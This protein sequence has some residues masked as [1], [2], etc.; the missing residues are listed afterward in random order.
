MS[1]FE[2]MELQTLTREIVA[3]RSRLTAV[4]S[5]GNLEHKRA[6]ETE[7]AAAEER[8]IGLIASISTNLAGRPEPE[9]REEGMQAAVTN[10]AVGNDGRIVWERLTPADLARAAGDLDQRRAEA[11]QRHAAE[12]SG[13]EAERAEME[14]L[15]EAIGAFVRKFNRP[16][17]RREIALLG[18]DCDVRLLAAG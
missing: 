16:G 5:G 2:W 9:Q 10:P 12:L 6:L 17:P 18:A 1:S 7:I 15:E 4:R 8:R 3:A 14:G 11:L 13:L